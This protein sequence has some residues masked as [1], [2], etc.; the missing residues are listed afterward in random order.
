MSCHHLHVGPSH[1]GQ[2]AVQIR[3]PGDSGDPE[4]LFV[5]SPSRHELLV[6]G[7][8]PPSRRSSSPGP[9]F[10][11]MCSIPQ[12]DPISSL[13]GCLSQPHLFVLT[14]SGHLSR[15]RF[16]FQPSPSTVKDEDD[17]VE[18]SSSSSS[19]SSSKRLR[20]DSSPSSSILRFAV[21]V[22]TEVN[23]SPK[24]KLWPVAWEGRVMLST[25]LG[26]A[27]A[28]WGGG[29][30]GRVPAGLQG[31]L[32]SCFSPLRSLQRDRRHVGLLN[33]ACGGGL[34]GLGT[35][36]ELA[37]VGTRDGRVFL[38]EAECCVLRLVLRLDAPVVQ[39]ELVMLPSV[40]APASALVAVTGVGQVHVVVSGWR[41]DGLVTFKLETQL[42]L[43]RSLLVDGRLVALS[44]GR[45]WWSV[46]TLAQLL[47]SAD[48]RGAN[49]SLDHGRF[50]DFHPQARLLAMGRHSFSLPIDSLHLMS[51]STQPPFPEAGESLVILTKKNSLAAVSLT[52]PTAAPSHVSPAQLQELLD[53]I[54]VVTAVAARQ[55]RKSESLDQ[56]IQ[57]AQRLHDGDSPST[58][59]LSPLYT[60]IATRTCS[61]SCSTVAAH[62]LD[63][64][65]LH[66]PVAE[67]RLQEPI[68]YVHQLLEVERQLFSFRRSVIDIWSYLLSCANLQP[69]DHPVPSRLDIIISPFL[70]LPDEPSL[71]HQHQPH[72]QQFQAS[73]SLPSFP[74][75]PSSLS[76]L[77]LSQR[78]SAVTTIHLRSQSGED[79]AT[80]VFQRQPSSETL[81]ISSRSLQLLLLLRHGLL[82]RCPAAP[83]AQLSLDR[84][85]KLLH[86]IQHLRS[87]LRS[88]PSLPHL[89]RLHRSL[90]RLLGVSF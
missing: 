5:V 30:G 77:L 52:L 10:E 19:S 84:T 33:A 35:T 63:L 87:S 15:Y 71:F 62:S 66:A 83:T 14:A 75:S 85:R 90:L 50:P 72:Q 2:C 81:K 11:R 36:E 53:A 46:A 28:A 76:A 41:R 6:L 56:S 8:V 44:G 54:E 45:L 74:A 13:S 25:P 58:A 31:G 43:D 3:R 7:V 38:L 21:D 23:V 39:A 68:Q 61:F 51:A 20:V 47:L 65:A 55:A 9:V 18:A 49:P 89:R 48:R 60:R 22:Q 37:L 79:F 69:R 26:A 16:S 57:L 40:P 67:W 42:P 88:S 1:G 29:K 64:R 70:S 24:W 82:C 32:W 27:M 4:A 17:V 59:P 12:T 78:F 86:L 34:S 80:L 73:I